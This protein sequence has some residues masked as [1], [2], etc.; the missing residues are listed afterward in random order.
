MIYRHETLYR[1]MV[2]YSVTISVLYGKG[3]TIGLLYNN[4]STGLLY[5]RGVTISLLYI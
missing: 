4:V 1:C 3:V 2:V 5:G